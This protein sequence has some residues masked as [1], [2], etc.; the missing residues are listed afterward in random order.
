MA[1]AFSVLFRRQPALI[2]LLLA[3]CLTLF[4][5]LG[6]AWRGDGFFAR[7]RPPVRSMRFSAQ[8]S[9]RDVRVS[10][11]FACFAITV[12]ALRFWRAIELSDSPAPHGAA[13]SAMLDAATLKYLDG[14]GEGCSETNYAPAR[15]RRVLHHLTFYGFLL[16]LAS[17]IVASLYHYALDWPA[18]YPW[19]SL[20]VLLG[21][22]GGIGL[23]IGPAGC[24]GCD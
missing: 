24:C 3:S 17:T 9:N 22:V 21:A 23:I 11:G 16:C 4:F 2:S 6:I 19:L 20:P 7:I 15:T 12:G 1:S 5:A 10:F 13:A 14:G 18:P 8:L